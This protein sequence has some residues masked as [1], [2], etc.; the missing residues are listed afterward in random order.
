M[1]RAAC[2][3]VLSFAVFA[4]AQQSADAP[5]QPAPDASATTLP[6]IRTLMAEVEE[7][8]KFADEQ[9]KDYTYRVHTENI[10]VDNNEQTKKTTTLDSDSFTIDGVRVNKVTERNGKPLT[11]DEAKKENES[12]DKTLDKAKAARAKHEKNGKPTDDQGDD[13]VTLGRFFDLGTFS[14]LRAGEYGGRPAWLVDYTGDPKAKTHNSFEGVIR[15]ITGTLWIDQHDH[16]LVALQGSFVHDFKIGAG[17]IANI[18]QG[19][20]FN[21]RF[22]R[23]DDVWLPA[24]INGNGN[25]R[26]LLLF[27]FHGHFHQVMSNYKKFRT[28]V[29]LLPGNQVINDHDEPKEN[30]APTDTIPALPTP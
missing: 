21:A 12:V 16:V 13:V 2:C 5:P 27:S 22:T 17:L 6:D 10:E 23:V 29:T 30:P 9:R 15:D 20:S 11:P 3:F 18:H 24:E 8:A 14:N 25:V 26:Y 1:R 4:C 19:A 7:H 28:G